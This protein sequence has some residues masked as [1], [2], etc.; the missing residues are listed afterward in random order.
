M[1]EKTARRTSKAARE[2][3][4]K[5]MTQVLPLLESAAAEPEEKQATLKKSADRAR[6][7]K[8]MAYTVEHVTK[9]IGDVQ[10]S[11]NRMLTDL[12]Q[13]LREESGKLAEI[14][15]AIETESARFRE[16]HDIDAA[17][18]SL[19]A[20]LEVA[21]ERRAELEG[22]LTRREAD[23]QAA[24]KRR[25]EEWER[26]QADYEAGMKRNRAR[27][28]EQYSYTLAMKRRTEGDEYSAK[29]AA[30]AKALQDQRA[31]ADREIE[32]RRRVVAARE[33]EMAALQA[34]IEQFP[35]EMAAAVKAAEQAVRSEMQKQAALDAR[36]AKMEAE[37]EKNITGLKIAGLEDLVKRQGA[38][39]ESL[40]KQLSA[41]QAQVQAMAVKAIEGAA[42]MKSTAA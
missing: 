32:E 13:Q 8:T 6:V 17:M 19:Q 29:Q 31:Q 10:L 40:M 24:I 15:L 42:G 39:I 18:V 16:L 1:K 37:A 12:S 30:L 5:E 36:L 22:E 4:E 25:N 11:V 27:E 3:A 35:Q 9:E 26:E 2:A 38:Q 28:E 41:A 34:R 21:A 7:E 23:I 14:R 33:T 20:V